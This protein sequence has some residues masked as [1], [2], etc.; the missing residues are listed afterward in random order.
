MCNGLTVLCEQLR[1]GKAI[2]VFCLTVLYNLTNVANISHCKIDTREMNEKHFIGSEWVQGYQAGY[3]RYRVWSRVQQVQGRAQGTEHRAQG[4]GYSRY[5]PGYRGT[6]VSR[7]KNFKLAVFLHNRLGQSIPWS[8][9]TGD[10]PVNVESFCHPSFFAARND[11][12]I[13]PI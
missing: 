8:S 2:F 4:T 1:S 10:Q 11:T 9:F 12:T 13:C 3:S 7:Y 6:T 5:R